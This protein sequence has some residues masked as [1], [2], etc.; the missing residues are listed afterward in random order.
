MLKKSKL[1]KKLKLKKVARVAELMDCISHRK[2]LAPLVEAGEIVPLGTG[3]YADSSLDIF[4]ATIIAVSR[5]FPKATISNA[6]ALVIHS[7]SDERIDRIDVDI[8]RSTSI[9]NKL[10]QAHRVPKSRIIGAVTIPY[11]GQKIRVYDPERSLADAYRTDPDGPIFLKAIKRYVRKGT[12]NTERIALYDR[13]LKT[14]VLRSVR[15]E[16][17]DE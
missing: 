7:L 4:V 6:T 5:Y 9:R 12:I 11:H 16:L 15:Q 1:L 10:V 3:I 14:N 8:E 13:K 17:A 2:E